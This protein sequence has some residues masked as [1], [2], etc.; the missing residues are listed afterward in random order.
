MIDVRWPQEQYART[1]GWPGQRFPL[2]PR[3]LARLSGDT[4]QHGGEAGFVYRAHRAPPTSTASAVSY[5]HLDVYKRQVFRNVAVWTP[6]PIRSTIVKV[7]IPT[8]SAS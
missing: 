4:T 2:L 8:M 6:V 3:L 1:A 5:T 7:P